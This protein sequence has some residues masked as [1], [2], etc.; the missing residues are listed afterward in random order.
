[1]KRNAKPPIRTHPTTAPTT[2]PAMPATF[3]WDGEGE[4]V[5]VGEVPLAGDGRLFSCVVALEKCVIW[6][7]DATAWELQFVDM[8]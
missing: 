2:P 6:K 3:V 4:G 5:R 1:M 7:S 8:L